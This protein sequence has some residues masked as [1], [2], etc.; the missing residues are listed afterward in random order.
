MATLK[1]MVDDIVLRLAGYGMRQDNQTYLD[2]AITADARSFKV[3]SAESMGKGQIEIGDELIW[4]DSFDRT[5]GLLTIPPYGRGYN[6]TEASSHAIHSKV[7]VNP[8]FTRAAIKNEINNTILA[9]YPFL[10]AIS[11]TQF[12]YLAAVNTYALPPEVK[13]VLQVTWQSI[14]PSKEWIPVRKWRSDS[15]AS[16]EAFNSSNSITV[17]SAIIPGRTVQVTYMHEPT[18]LEDD[19]D[20][21]ELVSGLPES[22]RDVIILGACYRLLSFIE[23]SRLSFSSPEADTQSGRIQYGSG[24]NVVKYIYALYQQR[25]QD[26]A[27]KLLDR[28]PVRVHYTS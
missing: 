17:N 14:G 27:N 4:V 21:F 1:N 28:F 2:T 10:Y 15:M 24:T 5:S 20:D 3:G 16:E 8:T 18:I 6:G 23:P 25:L 9:V 13:S 12:T 7:T 11:K 22:A 26:E 19:D